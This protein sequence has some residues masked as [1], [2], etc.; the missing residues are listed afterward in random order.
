M[1]YFFSLLL[2]VAVTITGI[3]QDGFYIKYDA[4]INSTSEEGEM[5]AMMMQGST[6]ELAISPE[7]NWVKTHV[8]S[9]MTMTMELNIAEKNTMT[10][11]M[12]GMM[13]TMAFRGDPDELKDD[14]DPETLNT[15]MEFF[16]E[17]KT[18]LG[19]ECKKATLTD[20]GGNTAVFWY[21][22]KIPRP[23]G[24]SQMPDQI[25]GLSLQFETAPQK[26][27]TVTYTAVQ[28]NE[29]ADMSEYQLIV[30]EGTEISDLK[31]MAKMGGG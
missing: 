18:I 7:K 8:G 1:K 25:P 31:D 10:M 3:A 24:V 16:N 4:A 28:I 9:M 27:V 14:I 30:P 21:T 23:E 19:Y 20:A 22:E 15:Q 17:T 11:L 29:Q 6:M 5:V 2:I 13:G 12:Q 26:G